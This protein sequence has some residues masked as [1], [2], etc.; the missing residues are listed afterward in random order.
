[1][2]AQSHGV[3]CSAW[4]FPFR[5]WKFENA[6]ASSFIAVASSAMCRSK[7]AEPQVAGPPRHHLAESLLD[8]RF[9]FLPLGAKGCLPVSIADSF[10]R[11]S[12]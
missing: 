2:T 11:N 9:V 5:H 7:I 12:T 3:L 10:V 8:R 1:M 4:R 6:R